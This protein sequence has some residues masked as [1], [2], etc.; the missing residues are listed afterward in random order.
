MSEKIDQSM[1]VDGWQQEFAFSDPVGEFSTK[2]L[3]WPTTFLE[4]AALYAYYGVQGFSLVSSFGAASGWWTLTNSF[5]GN[6]GIGAGAGVISGALKYAVADEKCES[7]LWSS[8]GA[9]LLTGTA[10][11]AIRGLYAEHAVDAGYPKGSAESYDWTWKKGRVGAGAAILDG[12]IGIAEYAWL[13]SI[14]DKGCYSCNEE[15]VAV[16]DSAV[17]KVWG[18]NEKNTDTWFVTSASENPN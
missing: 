7:K 2:K 5:W 18:C 6:M 16:A 3:E 13:S 9:G 4:S 8:M 15:E 14:N 17:G 1:Q 10:R 11:G 12:G